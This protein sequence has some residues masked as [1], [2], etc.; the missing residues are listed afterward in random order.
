MSDK[1]YFNELIR[2]M[3]ELRV[4]GSGE[5]VI[6]SEKDDG[7]YYD[8]TTRDFAKLSSDEKEALFIWLNKDDMPQA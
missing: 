6:P 8:F 3:K 1:N 2:K 4:S 5:I 7:L